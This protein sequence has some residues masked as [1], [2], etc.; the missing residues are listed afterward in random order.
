MEEEIAFIGKASIPKYQPSWISM[1]KSTGIG[2]M[3]YAMASN[4]RR[5]MSPKSTLVLYDVNHGACQRFVREFGHLGAVRIV[6][7]AKEA[8]EVASIVISIVPGAKEVR[9]IYLDSEKGAVAAAQDCQRILLDC[10][11]I[12]CETSR[13]VGEKLKAARAGHFC[14]APVS[15]SLSDQFQARAKWC[16]EDFQVPKQVPYPS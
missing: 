4:V 12:D 16:R 5:K 3:G 2:V 10:S 11:T 9:E 8:A 15:V 14:D 7:S 1:A 13:D 6:E